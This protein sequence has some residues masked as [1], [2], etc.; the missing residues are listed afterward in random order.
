M[1]YLNLSFI[2]GTLLFILLLMFSFFLKE[3]WEVR[4]IILPKCQSLGQLDLVLLGMDL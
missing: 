1:D 3:L 4:K 2:P